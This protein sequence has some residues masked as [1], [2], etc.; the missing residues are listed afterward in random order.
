M[1]LQPEWSKGAPA[2]VYREAGSCVEYASVWFSP[3]SGC[4]FALSS[5]RSVRFLVSACFE[6]HPCVPPAGCRLSIR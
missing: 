2:P 3:L 1:K 6:I 4:L 5:L